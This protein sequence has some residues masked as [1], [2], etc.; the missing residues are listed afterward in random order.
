MFILNYAGIQD[1]SLC[2]M[3]FAV[4]LVP[5]GWE[6]AA[7]RQGLQLQL[8]KLNVNLDKTLSMV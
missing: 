5:K 1:P 7:E 3:P 6:K 8:E 2:R 4:K